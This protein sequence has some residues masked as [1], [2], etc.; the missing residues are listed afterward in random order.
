LLQCEHNRDA[1]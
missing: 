1:T